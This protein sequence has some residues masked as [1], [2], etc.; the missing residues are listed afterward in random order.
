VRQRIRPSNRLGPWPRRQPQQRMGPSEKQQLPDDVKSR[1][2]YAVRCEKSA[3]RL[4]QKSRQTR[5]TE[6][7][8]RFEEAAQRF[9]ETAREMRRRNDH[10]DDFEVT[11]SKAETSPLIIGF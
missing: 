2:A 10:A 8:K 7:R 3:E 9:D 11:V 5:C 6:A 1:E 4:R